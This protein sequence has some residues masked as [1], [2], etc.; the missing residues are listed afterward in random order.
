[1][2]DRGGTDMGAGQ[3]VPGALV[4]EVA[5]WR[6]GQAAHVIVV[7]VVVVKGMDGVSANHSC[8]NGHGHTPI[9]TG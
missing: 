4:V 6:Q 1:M 3:G 5:A 7:M 9:Q 8:E 2:G